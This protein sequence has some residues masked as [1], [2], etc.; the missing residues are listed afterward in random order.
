MI[1]AARIQHVSRC[2]KRGDALRRGNAM[3]EFA[4]VFVLFFIVLLTTMEMGRGM[5][6]YATIATA[7]RRAGDYC[8]VHGS[9]RPPSSASDITAVVLEHTKGLDQSALTVTT[10]YNP[11]SDSPFTDPTAVSRNDIAEI[12]VTYLF[13]LV[14]GLVIPDNQ[15]PMT[16]TTRVVVAN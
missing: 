15:M 1:Q 4:F 10:T 6:A 7:T 16:S 9:R 8:M 5:W 3:I 2:R 14:T 11:D 13:R 12:R